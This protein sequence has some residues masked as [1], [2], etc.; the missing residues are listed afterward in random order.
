[1][2]PHIEAQPGDYADT[3]LMP[4]DPLRAAYIA[5]N[6][7]E[8][9]KQVNSVRNCLG[10]TGWYAGHRV[11]VQASGMGQP[12]L[13]IYATELFD[14]YG[15]ERIIR[16]GTCGAFQPWM[17]LGDLVIPL[18]AASDSQLGKSDGVHVAPC[19]SH[20]LLQKII[21]H[22]GD[23]HS[24]LHFGSLYSSDCFYNT[25][26]DWWIKYREAGVLGVDMETYYLYY[27]ALIRKKSAITINT[28]S[29]NFNFATKLT[30]TERIT[31]TRMSVDLILQSL[32]T[33]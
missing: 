24:R 8:R 16:I 28:V 1:M 15:V 13:G 21:E 5:E 14:V 12:S 22:A 7:L 18:S 6:F 9:C 25:P 23:L 29:D 32:F 26:S 20:N 3:V 4:G 11:S 10:F 31:H 17:G 27:L 19:C 33:P 30:P 2:T